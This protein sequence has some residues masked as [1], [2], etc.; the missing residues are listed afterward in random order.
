M[1]VDITPFA[2]RRSATL[3]RAFAWS[4]PWLRG[5][6]SHVDALLD[7][8]NQLFIK[9]CAGRPSCPG[10]AHVMSAYAAFHKRVFDPATP[11]SQR[12]VLVIRES[13]SDIVGIGQ[14]HYGFQRLT[15]LAVASGRAIVFSSCESS[16]DKWKRQGS[17]LLNKASPYRCDTPHLNIADFYRGFDGIDLRW[18]PA[19]K[20]LMR[21]CGFQ[22]NVVDFNDRRYVAIGNTSRSMNQFKKC[23]DKGLSGCYRGWNPDQMYCDLNAKR[24]CPAAWRIFGEDHGGCDPR[25]RQWAAELAAAPWQA[26]YNTRRDGGANGFPIWQ[27]LLANGKE[28]FA[29]PNGSSIGIASA[30]AL[31]KA[32]TCPYR[33]WAHVSFRPGRRLRKSMETALSKLDPSLP[34]ICAHA[35]TL[36]VDDHR[37]FPNGRGCHKV[38][39]RRLSYWDTKR[40]ITDSSRSIGHGPDAR[41]AYDGPTGHSS[42]T[43]GRE[44]PLWWQLQLPKPLPV[45]KV[46]VRQAD[47]ARSTV[48]SHRVRSQG[49]RLLELTGNASLS[50]W[51]AEDRLL[52]RVP[53]HPNEEGAF[54][55]SFATPV[56]ATKVRVE[57]HFDASFHQPPNRPAVLSLSDFQVFT[58]EALSWD[59]VDSYVQNDTCAMQRWRGRCVG[60]AKQAQTVL[61]ALGGWSGFVR[62]MTRPR[63]QNKLLTRPG[64]L[65]LGRRRKGKRVGGRRLS[66]VIGDAAQPAQPFFLTSDALGLQQLADETY[67]GAVLAIPAEPVASWEAAKQQSEYVKVIADYEVLKLCDA[68]V[69]PIDST[70]ARAAVDSSL[71]VSKHMSADE[72]C[73]KRSFVCRP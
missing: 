5:N 55:A 67:P 8:A 24:R 62:C 38:E 37:C 27:L 65:K 6:T 48:R 57:R 23:E 35:R 21:Q 60:W 69:S 50:L 29:A 66:F 1:C 17:D 2:R 9:Q 73:T 19:R 46:S 10:L 28:S 32:L 43:V 64:L 33:C 47:P 30:A 53:L 61:P 40:S 42:F 13:W 45:C 15:A 4:M 49:V 20:R 44:S 22:E 54:A 56:T 71:V 25:G 14:M 36:H 11:C 7:N 68:I 52:D 63:F 12:R 26:W 16:T 18:T 39:F 51:S 59:V 34:L 31:R 72:M 58:D 70:Y 41:G 3:R